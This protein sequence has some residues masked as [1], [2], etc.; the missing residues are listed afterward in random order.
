A[1]RGGQAHKHRQKGRPPR[2]AAGGQDPQGQDRRP[3]ALRGRRP[4][5]RRPHLGLHPYPEARPAP[6]GRR[7]ERLPG[8]RQ[9]QNWL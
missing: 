9:L 3:S 5:P 2:P 4:R 1:R 7:R 8:A 6:R